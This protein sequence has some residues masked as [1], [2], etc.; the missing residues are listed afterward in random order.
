MTTVYIVDTNVVVSGVIGN[1]LDSPPARIVDA[2]LDGGFL[3]SLS[4]EL[5]H[6]YADILRRPRIAR[7][8]GWTD[9]QLDRFLTDLVANSVWREPAATEPA[10]DPG[11][12][13]LWA[14][15]AAHR[16]ACL[17]TGDQLLVS[18]PRPYSRV[19]TPRQFVEEFLTPRKAGPQT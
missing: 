17:V 6:E 15:L 2:M 11:D 12:D 3:Y 1:D 13:H 7:I 10:P 9:E 19:V 8:H 5:L 16:Q 4:P 18:N 14:L